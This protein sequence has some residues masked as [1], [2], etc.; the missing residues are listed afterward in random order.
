MI[1]FGVCKLSE[2]GY[3]SRQQYFQYDYRHPFYKCDSL[4]DMRTLTP[5]TRDI[6]GLAILFCVIRHGVKSH[7]LDFSSNEKIQSYF[8]SQ[9]VDNH[10]VKGRHE[11]IEEDEVLK[12]FFI[13]SL[14]WTAADEGIQD[15]PL[16]F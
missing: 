15:I 10:R 13:E 16:N 2:Y 8:N 4:M 12:A 14:G 7:S 9:R 6:Y 1:D 11:E 5:K 3:V